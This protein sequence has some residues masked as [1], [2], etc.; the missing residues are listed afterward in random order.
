MFLLLLL[1]YQPRSQTQ[2]LLA[3][4]LSHCPRYCALIGRSVSNIRDRE[5]KISVIFTLLVELK[6]KLIYRQIFQNFPGLKAIGP[7]GILRST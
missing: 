5:S 6:H 4:L 2:R 3:R 7:T 1:S